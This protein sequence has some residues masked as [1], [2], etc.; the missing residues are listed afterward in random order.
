MKPR[1]T[2]LGI[3]LDGVIE[4]L[5]PRRDFPLLDDVTYLNAAS[6]GLVPLPV[7]EQV[8]AF[9]RELAGVPH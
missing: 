5:A 7:Q 2:Y 3:K 4:S 9:D 6:M 8:A 1:N